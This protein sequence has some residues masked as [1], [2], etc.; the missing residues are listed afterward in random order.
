MF[1]LVRGGDQNFRYLQR[2]RSRDRFYVRVRLQTNTERDQWRQ[3]I[4]ANRT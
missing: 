3:E 2:Q 1:M 4:S